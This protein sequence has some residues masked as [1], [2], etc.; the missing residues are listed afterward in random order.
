MAPSLRNGDLTFILLLLAKIVEPFYAK[1]QAVHIVS[2]IHPV[3]VHLRVQIR[4]K[5]KYFPRP[6]DAKRTPHLR[7]IDFRKAVWEGTKKTHFAARFSLSWCRK[8]LLIA[9][10]IL[11][12]SHASKASAPG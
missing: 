7:K 4:D 1:E 11:Q 10:K 9:G 5:R 2:M 3:S 12:M 8:P 6:L